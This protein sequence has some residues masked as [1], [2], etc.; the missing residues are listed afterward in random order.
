MLVVPSRNLNAS[1][2]LCTANYTPATCA[3]HSITLHPNETCFLPKHTHFGSIRI[4]VIII[5][6]ILGN[7]A[8]Y[9]GLVKAA[10]AEAWSGTVNP[11]GLAVSGKEIAATTVAEAELAGRMSVDSVDSQRTAVLTGVVVVVRKRKTVFVAKQNAFA[12]VGLEGQGVV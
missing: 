8:E 4:Y 3:P 5:F 2:L 7:I 6:H 1:N 11:A 12:A 9:H 10:E